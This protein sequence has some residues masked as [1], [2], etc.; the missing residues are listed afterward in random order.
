MAQASSQQAIT[1]NIET[2]TS[3]MSFILSQIFSLVQSEREI[4][5]ASIE[6]RY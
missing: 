3:G 6:K 2:L 4:E 5:T 1:K